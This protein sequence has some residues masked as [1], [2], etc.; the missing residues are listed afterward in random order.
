M[1]ETIRTAKLMSRHQTKDPGS[2]QN[3]VQNKS[4]THTHTNIHTTT[5]KKLHLGIWFSDYRKS[6]TKKKILKEAEEK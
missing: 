5:N 4:H 1:Y 3:I 6:K 2:S